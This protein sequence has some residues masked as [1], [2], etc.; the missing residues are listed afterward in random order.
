VFS[1]TE[2]HS[3]IIIRQ[4]FRKTDSI[5]RAETPGRRTVDGNLHDRVFVKGRGA[6][7]P[8]GGP[9]F[10]SWRGLRARSCSTFALAGGKLLR[11]RLRGP[12]GA[13]GDERGDVGLA[14]E[15]LLE[16]VNSSPDAEFFSN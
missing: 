7:L 3:S 16:V 6:L 4:K 5:F 10:P 11:G 9:R 13:L 1:V 2:A 15:R 14:H 12:A 8:G